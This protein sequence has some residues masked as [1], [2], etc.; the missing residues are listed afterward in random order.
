MSMNQRGRKTHHHNFIR[1]HLREGERNG[2]RKRNSVC[3]RGHWVLG[4]VVDHEAP[5]AR[6]LC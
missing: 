1:T 5:G 6:L 3:Y 4:L 2:R